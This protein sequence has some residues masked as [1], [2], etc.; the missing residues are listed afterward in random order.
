M[1]PP[2]HYPHATFSCGAARTARHQL[3]NELVDFL[4]LL[5]LPAALGVD[6][7]AAHAALQA[8]RVAPLLA[9]QADLL[10]GVARWQCQVPHVSQYR[11]LAPSPGHHAQQRSRCTI[12]EHTWS[13]RTCIC[14]CRGM[15]LVG[16][17]LLDGHLHG[18]FMD[19]SAIKCDTTNCPM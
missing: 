18:R 13:V 14:M 8:G 19:C 15:P 11:T 7:V 5:A 3:L 12:A 16:V 1:R 4:R 17:L 2:A 6:D 10:H 9:H